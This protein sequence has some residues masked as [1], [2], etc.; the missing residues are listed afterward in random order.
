MPFPHELLVLRHGQTRWNAEG[1]WQGRLNSPL[2]PLGIRQATRQGE[3]L[4][5]L[6]LSGLAAFSS[7]S[8]RAIETAGIAVAP[9]LDPVRTDDRLMEIDVGRWSGRLRGELMPMRPDE[10]FGDEALDLYWGAPGGEGPGPLRARC[11]A[12]LGGLRGPAVLVCHGIT[13]RMLRAVALG[14]GDD[15]LGDLPGGQG[16]VHRI[17]GGAQEVLR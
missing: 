9:H 17:A 1:R 4:A 8:G 12:F 10:E 15:A 11:T 2:T 5:G 6:D 7:P 3:I 16:V 13:G 14:L